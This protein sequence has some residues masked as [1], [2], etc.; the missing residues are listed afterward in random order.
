MNWDRS[1]D[2]VLCSTS[3]GAHSCRK[4]IVE[5]VVRD[6]VHFFA[7]HDDRVI[8]PV[9][10]F[11]KRRISKITIPAD[12]QQHVVLDGRRFETTAVC[13]CPFVVFD[14]ENPI[15]ELAE[16]VLVAARP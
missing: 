5:L 1:A 6:A 8:S 7:R 3:K 15:D 16:A 2:V 10:P 11:A 4:V 13:G 14:P 12:D 9:K